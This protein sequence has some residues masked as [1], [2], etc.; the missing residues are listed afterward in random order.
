M[1]PPNPKNLTEDEWQEI[2]AAIEPE[3]MPLTIQNISLRHGLKWPRRS[4]FWDTFTVEEC[5]KRSYDELSKLR[6]MGLNKLDTII[7]CLCRIAEDPDLHTQES[8]SDESFYDRLVNS[9]ND[10]W[11][12]TRALWSEICSSIPEEQQH[13]PIKPI[14]H[15]LG[16]KWPSTRWDDFQI[17]D[18]INKS[19]QDLLSTPK[20][21]K[22]KM[23]VIALSLAYVASGGNEANGTCEDA[24]IFEHAVLK[25]LKNRELSV[26]E[27]RVLEIVNKDT[28]EELAAEFGV[29]RERIRQVESL[30]IRRIQS[31]SLRENLTQIIGIC[32]DKVIK[33]HS[34]KRFIKHIQIEDIAGEMSDEEKLAISFHHRHIDKWL[35]SF[36][37]RKDHGWFVGDSAEF[38]QIEKLGKKLNSLQL[39]ISTDQVVTVTG[40]SKPDLIAYLEITGVA[41]HVDGYVSP[42]SHGA[43]HAKRIIPVYDFA[44]SSGLGFWRTDELIKQSVSGI[45]S[46]SYRN[47]YISVRSAKHLF[48]TSS[49]FTA[50]LRHSQRPQ[51]KISEAE[52]AGLDIVPDDNAGTTSDQKLSDVLHNSWP[53]S[54]K[55]IRKLIDSDVYS[56]S[57]INESWIA[58]LASDPSTYRIAP[59]VY[60]P[61]GYEQDLDRLNRARQIALNKRDLRAYCFAKRSGENTE[62]IYPLWDAEQ[63]Q[64][65]YRKIRKRTDDPL[66]HSL[67]SIAR[68]D[69]WP[70]QCDRER[71]E[72]L[73]LKV[74]SKFQITPNW[75]NSRSYRSPTLEETLVVS[76]YARDIAPVSWVRA[77]SLLSSISVTSEYGVSAVILGVALGLLDHDKRPW[78]KP[79]PASSEFDEK[80]AQLES[81][82][83]EGDPPSWQHLTIQ[84]ILEDSLER[85][86][87]MELGFVKRDTLE[88]IIACL[89]STT[90][91]EEDQIFDE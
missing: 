2:V 21:G 69:L 43:S 66:L 67:V 46:A 84:R 1:E 71:L 86:S 60:A 78:W 37:T 26:Y 4:R 58:K 52:K 22:T 85:S 68:Q 3:C 12:L 17:K 64:R 5:C 53:I 49:N 44:L 91:P 11:A 14:A 59:G 25:N 75:I 19:A 10:W 90:T 54:G 9:G 55:N 6:G 51:K 79:V 83:L 73:D 38:K 70:E 57:D 36:L 62:E 80:W 72:I 63:E 47:H 8:T 77:N 39:P 61:H 65:W 88:N 45:N 89:G 18:C 33:Q 31:S 13:L 24:S 23:R 81:L 56:S 50:I 27:R 41:S 30:I 76:R 74:S 40:I 7:R 87:K 20:I 35:S 48:A 16:L 15:N 29:T 32:K 28:L 82:H 34:E 42:R